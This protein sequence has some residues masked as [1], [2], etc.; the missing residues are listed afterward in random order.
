MSPLLARL[1]HA[2]EHQGCPLIGVER[3]GPADGQSD[4]NDPQGTLVKLLRAPAG[5]AISLL[6]E[7][8]PLASQNHHDPCFA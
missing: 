2:D 8:S 1:R 6:A 7:L 5:D 4:A 3:K